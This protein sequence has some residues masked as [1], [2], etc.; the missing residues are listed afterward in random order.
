M[1]NSALGKLL[2]I[3]FPW[4]GARRSISIPPRPLDGMLDM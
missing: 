1:K 2:S 4:H 3:I